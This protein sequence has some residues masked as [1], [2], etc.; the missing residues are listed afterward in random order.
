MEHAMKENP[1]F[2][3]FGRFQETPKAQ[4][5]PDMKAAFD[6]TMKLRG[7]VPGFAQ[8]LD[9]Q[10][11]AVGDHRSDRSLLPDQIHALKSRDRDRH[12]RHQRSL[13][14]VFPRGVLFLP[15]DVLKEKYDVRRMAVGI[16]ASTYWS[17]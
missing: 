9:L 14:W 13:V 7:E 17:W 3:S 16:P 8:D 2:G 10:S 15:K 5:S 12:Q 4:M 6:F 1:V 11:E